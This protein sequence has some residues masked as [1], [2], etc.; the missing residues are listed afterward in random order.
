MWPK[1]SAGSRRLALDPR[2]KQREFLK[3][4]L[5]LFRER[6]ADGWSRCWRRTPTQGRN[7]QG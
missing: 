6:E 2:S 4:L 3:D 7:G 5:A 1:K